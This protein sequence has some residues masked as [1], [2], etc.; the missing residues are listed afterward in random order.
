MNSAAVDWPIVA[1]LGKQRYLFLSLVAFLLVGPLLG[2]E[3]GGRAV[4][5]TVLALVLITGPLAV[6]T[7]KS[8]LYGSFALAVLVLATGI[9]SVFAKETIFW[10]VSTLFGILFFGYVAALVM[11]E[12]LFKSRPVDAE[13]LWA[14]INVY[15]LIGVAFSFLYAFSAI[16]DPELFIGKFMDE[17]L[18]DQVYGFVYFSFVTLTTLGYGDITPNQPFVATLTFI[19]A[20][21]GQLYLAILIARLVGLYIAQREVDR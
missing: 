16:I 5:Y 13:V 18:R 3:F 8:S 11:K 9:L 12:L 14:A 17:P 7:T 6:A 1:R 21:I 2:G 19:E 4:M 10:G 15:L 20:L